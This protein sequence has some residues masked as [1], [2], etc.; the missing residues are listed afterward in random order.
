MVEI[1]QQ[2]TDDQQQLQVLVE[3]LKAL[4]DEIALR[5]SEANSDGETVADGLAEAYGKH[6]Q[7][8]DAALIETDRLLAEVE[9][10]KAAQVEALRGL[11][12]IEA[13]SHALEATDKNLADR[14]AKINERASGQ[15]TAEAAANEAL[16]NSTGK[17]NCC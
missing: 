8:L 15:Q 3:R 9:Q 7:D 17:N 11:D 13:E 14:A 16:R 6:K 2:E 10:H 4:A 12:R 1:D 5:K